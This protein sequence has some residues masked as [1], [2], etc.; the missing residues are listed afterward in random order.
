MENENIKRACLRAAG[1]SMAVIFSIVILA[2]AGVMMQRGGLFARSSLGGFPAARFA[3]YALA[4]LALWLA[5]TVRTNGLRRAASAADEARFIHTMTTAS[6]LAAAVCELPALA[7]FMLTALGGM[8]AD[9]LGLSVFSGLL[10]LL[11]LP[12]NERWQTL[13]SQTQH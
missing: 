12:K 3:A 9:L 1:A 4:A 8:T 13:Y 11:N 6:T 7:G 10:I 2:F 5:K